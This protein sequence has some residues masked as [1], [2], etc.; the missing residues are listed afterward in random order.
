MIT[1]Q[2]LLNLFEYRDGEIFYKVTRSRNKA[3]SKAGTYRKHDNAYQ[4]IIDKKHYL[5]HRVIFMM[6]YGYL[7][8]Y[9]D[10]IDGNRSNNKIENLRPATL[11][12]NAQN[13]KLRKDSISGI[14]NVSWNK[15]DKSWK[16]RIQVNNKR[17]TIGQ[18][19]DLEL[20]ALVAEEARDKYHKQFANHGAA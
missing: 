4:V 18:F 16:V 12:Q 7:P 10:H 6:H 11:N 19:K 17:I 14:K 13:A 2:K 20:A 5:L 3:G 15:V 1:Q 9:V 8:D